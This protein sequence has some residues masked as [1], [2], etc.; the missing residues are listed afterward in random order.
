VR[1]YQSVIAADVKADTRKLY[2]TEQ[3]TSG[4]DQGNSSVKN[5]V[6]RRRAFLLKTIR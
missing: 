1:Q 3:F 5:F 6:D 2:P 4:I